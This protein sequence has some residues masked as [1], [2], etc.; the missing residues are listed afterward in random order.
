MITLCLVSKGILKKPLLYISD[1]METHRDNYYRN[2]MTVRTDND[3][4][5]WFKFFLTGVIDTAEKGIR[6][7]DSIL[8]LQRQMDQRI[9]TLGRSLANTQKVMD[10]LYHKP[11]INAVTVSEITG[12]SS[13]SAYRLVSNLEQ[14]GILKEITGGKRK[15][16]YL[17]ADYLNLFR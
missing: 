1:F 10:Y 13:P 16:E 15:R 4:S 11:L 9:Q 12:I 6:T 2:L 7:F 14:L 5:R 17:F 3:I 8:Q